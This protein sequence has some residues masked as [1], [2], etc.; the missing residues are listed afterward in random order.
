[1]T[2][3][4]EIAGRNLRLPE[5]LTR[6]VVVDRDLRVPMDD[7]VELLADRWRPRSFDGTPQPTVLVRSPYGRSQA[8]GFVWG[9]LLAERGFQ[10]LIQSTRGSFG[11]GGTFSPFDERADGL[12]TLRWIRAQPW[13]GGKIGTTGPSY[14]GLVQWA[15]ADSVDVMAPSVTASKFRDM[16]YG[17]G[18]V[19][20]DTALSWLLVLQTQELRF[21][22]VRLLDGLRRKLPGVFDQI[23]MADLDTAA[24]GTEV[25]IWREW[26][27]EMAPDSPYW[28]SRDFSSSVGDTT[29]PVQLMGGWYDIFLP[30]LV[31][32]WSALRARDRRTQLI[33]GPWAHTS[34][35]LL[36]LSLRDGMAWLR[37]E[38]HGDD[39]LVADTPVRV[40]VTGAREWRDLPDW[41]PPG[42]SDLTLHLA[43][44]GTLGDAPAPA[45]AAPVRFTYDPD[46]P[47][48]SLGGPTL[49]ENEPVRDQAPLESR[50][51]VVTFTGAPLAAPVEALG[52]VT[53]S[54]RF[55]SSRADTDVFVRVCDIDAGGVSRNVCDALVRLTADEPARDADGSARVDFPLWPT[56]H[57]FAA[58]HRIRIQVSSGAHP[59]YARNP[60]SGENPFEATEL[61][62]ADQEILFPSSVTLTVSG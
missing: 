9:R 27:A 58:G 50:A 57:R 16:A 18:S 6:D 11:S 61:L 59:R 55:R 47:T 20:L 31:E 26:L 60:G 15:I 37:A 29:A 7:G 5:P 45:D 32:D 35:G 52:P 39:R 44:T 2:L 19:S 51:D 8:A 53:A 13:H 4:S 3:L 46:D 42:S 43:P 12:A 62:R 40:Y 49:F 38:L 56:A 41:P 21:G 28:A 34:P 22:V 36:G 33:I 30:W 14:L 25:P 48:P 1:M 54:L 24:F 10:V 17:G 23:P